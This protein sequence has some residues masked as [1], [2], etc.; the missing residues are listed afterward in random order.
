MTKLFLM[1]FYKIWKQFCCVHS[2]RKK[3]EK[4]QVYII[5]TFR[6]I[7]ISSLFCSVILITREEGNFSL[8]SDFCIAWILG[9][10]G[11]KYPI[12]P[13][14]WFGVELSADFQLRTSKNRHYF[15]QL[16][17]KAEENIMCV[18]K[19]LSYQLPTGADAA[20][21]GSS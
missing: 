20:K 7:Y 15:M 19:T 8:W 9:I 1:V 21:S 11:V 2:V 5:S 17:W 12:I 4:K 3:I 18:K 6:I 14:L 13:L 16:L 10:R